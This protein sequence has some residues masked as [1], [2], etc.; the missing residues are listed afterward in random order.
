MHGAAKVVSQSPQCNG[1]AFALIFLC[2]EVQ[3]D[4]RHGLN[5]VKGSNSEIKTTLTNVQSDVAEGEG[6]IIVGGASALPWAQEEE[7]SHTDDV[8]KRWLRRGGLWAGLSKVEE[9]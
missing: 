5:L 4:P 6:G 7:E 1:V 2:C 3:T 9:E 8:H